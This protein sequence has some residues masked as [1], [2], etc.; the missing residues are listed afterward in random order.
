M[1]SSTTSNSIRYQ[2]LLAVIDK[3]LQNSRDSFDTTAAITECYGDDASI[4]GAATLEKL[5][6]SLVERVNDS[7]HV[8]VLE[9]L[10]Q[11]Q[12][13]EKL[14]QVEEIIQ[15][16]DQAA[17]EKRK[18][19][20]H[21]RTSATNALQKAKLPEGIR[22]EDVVSH[23]AFQILKQEESALDAELAKLQEETK[24]MEEQIAQAQAQVKQSLGK[25]EE[26]G[27]KLEQTADSCSFVS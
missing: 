10:Q 26:T 9:K 22:P 21:D 24:L 2:K 15:A 1:S 17:R 18:L 27:A 25:V 13:E 11:L 8:H 16:L 6:E 14:I 3:A 5:L 20:E 19:E 23:R 12:V 4:F 7:A